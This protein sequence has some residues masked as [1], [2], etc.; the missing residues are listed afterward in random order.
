MRK[1]ITRFAQMQALL[2]RQRSLRH[3]G[4]SLS[5]RLDHSPTELLRRI[6]PHL[7]DIVRLPALLCGTSQFQI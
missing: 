6:E 5:T 3:I 2:T 1:G 7:F 4:Q